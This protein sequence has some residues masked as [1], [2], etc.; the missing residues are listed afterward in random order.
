MHK[1]IDYETSGGTVFL[2]NKDQK[3][4]QLDLKKLTDIEHHHLDLLYDI[5]IPPK[6][7]KKNKTHLRDLVNEK[8][9]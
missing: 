2:V 8:G 3:K 1:T 6:S 9:K 5:G 7:K 4:L